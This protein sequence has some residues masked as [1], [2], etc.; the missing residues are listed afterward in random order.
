M[1]LDTRLADRTANATV[2]PLDVNLI[3]HKDLSKK[4]SS[5]RSSGVKKAPK[6]ATS[7]DSSDQLRKDLEESQQNRAALQA[8]LKSLNE[9]TE[10]I[11]LQSATDCKRINDLVSER[12]SLSVKMR[13]RDEELRDKKKLL[14]V[15]F[16]R[17]MT[18][19]P[20]FT[21]TTLRRIYMTKRS[22]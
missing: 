18:H 19:F 16:T 15:R 13:D 22:P 8:Q 10:K 2:S 6:E 14:E 4:P 21:C 3:E 9:E 5:E 12:A 20:S 17:L 1:G 11:R 7:L